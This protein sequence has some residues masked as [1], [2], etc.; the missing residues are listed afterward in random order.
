MDFLHL[1]I[2]G[3]I[4]TTI[5]VSLFANAHRLRITPVD[6]HFFMDGQSHLMRTENKFLIYFPR[7]LLGGLA[8]PAVFYYIWGPN[9][10][11]GIEP[12]GSIVLSAIALAL[13]EAPLMVIGIGSGIMKQPRENTLPLMI[14]AVIGHVNL[15]F[16]IGWFPVSP[17]VS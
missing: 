5:S 15:G 8:F 11:L 17:I 1:I 10:I 16:W 12:H 14:L 4:G 3:I 9:G 7:F 13:L 2:G 6:W